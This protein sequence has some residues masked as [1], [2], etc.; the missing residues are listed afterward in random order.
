MNELHLSQ[1]K[2]TYSAFGDN[3]KQIYKI[4]LDKACF[5]YDAAYFNIKGLAK[6]TISDK[7]LKDKGFWISID[8]KYDGYQRRLT[9]MVYMFWEINKSVSERE[10]E[11][12]SI[13]T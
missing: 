8:P 3:L 12:S 4:E 2:F 9:S 13:I 7:N 10:W 11:G 1:P 5:Y 6:R